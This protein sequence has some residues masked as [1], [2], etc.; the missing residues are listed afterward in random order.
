MIVDPDFFN[1]WKTLTL[2]GELDDDQLAPVYVL[3][4]WAHCQNRR[5]WRFK[6]SA[7]ALKAL[8][9]YSGHPDKLLAGLVASGFVETLDDGELYVRG[10]DE[11]NAQLI[12]NWENGKK[13][14]RPK[15]GKQPDV[16]PSETHGLPIDNPS[17]THQEP[18]RV[19]RSR[20][21]K[22]KQMEYEFGQFWEVVTNRKR[23]DDA[24]KAF[25]SQ[26][27]HH[28][29]EHIVDMARK[30]YSQPI[31]TQYLKHP[32]PFLRQYLNDDPN[33]WTS[34]E[35]KADRFLEGSEAL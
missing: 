10:W 29:L 9:H 33:E 27:K 1:H 8:C 17:E 2:I 16:N 14:G 31:E 22:T 19:D 30:Y 4:L 12:A 28:S 23:K 35:N 20:E 18:I 7:K 15:K 11:Y 26:R 5:D 34:R 24:K 25:Q 32:G 6:L 21:D 13:G 3:R